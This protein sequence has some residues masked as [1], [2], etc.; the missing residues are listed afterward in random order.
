MDPAL[1]YR[2]RDGRTLTIE[3]AVVYLSVDGAV[4]R[5]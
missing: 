5:P 4:A 3:G 1:A 2:L